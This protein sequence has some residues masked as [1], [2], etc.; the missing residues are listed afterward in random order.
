M[1]DLG[2]GGPRYSVI[3]PHH[4]DA[5]R[6]ERLLRS[7]PPARADIEIIVIDDCSPDRAPL[8]ALRPRW[9]AVRWLS[10]ARNL[11]AGAARNVGLAHAQGAWLV[12]ADSDDCFL[13]DAFAAFDA[14]A[15]AGLDLV[16]FLA[17]ARQEVDGTPSIRADWLNRFLRAWLAAPSEDTLKRLAANHVVP[18][19]K[20]YAHAFIRRLDLRFEEI[21]F[22]NDVAFNVLAAMQAQQVQVVPQAV[23]VC[24]RRPNS[25]TANRQPQAFLSRLQTQARL[26]GRFKALGLERG[27]LPGR[28]GFMMTALF[29]YGPATA[30][31][32]WRIMHGSDMRPLQLHKLFNLALWYR[33]LRRHGR[34]MRERRRLLP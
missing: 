9:P 1:D 11:G 32:A 12:F 28:S 10:T 26:A 25:L 13:P 5:Q 29:E 23:Y 21:M 4:D 16:Y 6:L 19:A 14:H 30:W 18:W 20:V 7:I 31:A 17:E 33:Y 24:T 2:T 3:I 34:D 22:S 27:Y 8:E 15:A